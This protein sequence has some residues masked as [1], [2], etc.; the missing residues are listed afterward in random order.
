[1]SFRQTIKATE[2][3]SCGFG[4]IVNH[5]KKRVEISFKANI[6]DKTIHKEWL[7]TVEDRIGLGELEPQPYWGFEDL[8]HKIGNKLT[9]CVYVLV[10]NK[11]INGIQHLRYCDMYFLSD[12]S[13]ASIINAIEK[14]ILFIDF[15]ARTGHNHGTKFRIKKNEIINLYGNSVKF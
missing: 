11:R 14:G 12:I 10:E 8:T 3:T 13:S 5:D 4:I 6:V 7:E 15:D 2:R 1:M 9:N